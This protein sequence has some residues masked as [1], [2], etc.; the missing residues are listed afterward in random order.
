MS[1]ANLYLLNEKKIKEIRDQLWRAV[2]CNRQVLY[3][4]EVVP[5]A[6]IRTHCFILKMVKEGSV[7]SI[8][9]IGE[10][11]PVS[12]MSRKLTAPNNMVQMILCMNLKW[13]SRSSS[14]KYPGLTFNTNSAN[15]YS[16]YISF[17]VSLLELSAA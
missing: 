10:L 15:K 3:E 4:Q 8:P 14:Q 11:W 17:L 1:L 13:D 9:P 16:R 5:T 2:N 12:R 6:C 7:L